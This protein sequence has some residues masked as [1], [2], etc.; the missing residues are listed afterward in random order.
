M[1][2]CQ[3][4]GDN[5]DI[6]NQDDDDLP[7]SEVSSRTWRAN[8]LRCRSPVDQT[9]DDD[10]QNMM[11][12]LLTA[13]EVEAAMMMISKTMILMTIRMKIIVTM[14]MMM[15]I[16]KTMVIMMSMIKIKNLFT[17]TKV[18][19]TQSVAMAGKGSNLG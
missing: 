14:I 11:K 10:I 15:K 4:C 18:E 7:G 3:D 16:S 8:Q 19:V 6:D 12:N 17:A 2:K 1:T 5:D 13:S 9:N